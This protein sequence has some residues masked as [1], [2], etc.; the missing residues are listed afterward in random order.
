ML[1]NSAEPRRNPAFY[2]RKSILVLAAI[3]FAAVVFGLTTQTWLQAEVNEGAAKAVSIAIP[4]SKAAT[5]VT[6]FAVVAVAGALA[7]AISGRIGRIISAAVIL[8]A[9]AG[10]LTS[11]VAVLADPAGAANGPVGA[12]TGVTGVPLQ[13]TTTPLVWIA[14]VAGGLLA[15]VALAVIV[16]GRQWSGAKKYTRSAE[17]A[18]QVSDDEPLDDIDS[19]DQLSRGKDPTSSASAAT[20]EETS[21]RPKPTDLAE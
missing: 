15:L 1:E 20:A 17:S 14:V 9:A 13:V 5:T 2:R 21:G 7:A 18:D 19:W 6:A 3:V 4:G 16:F 11:S 12:Q 10:V 8:L